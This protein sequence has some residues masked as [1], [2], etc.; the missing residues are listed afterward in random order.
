MAAGDLQVQC[1][2][3][4]C[5]GIDKRFGL[6][7]AVT[8]NKEV[9]LR[10]GSRFRKQEPGRTMSSTMPVGAGDSAHAETVSVLS[11]IA[12][13]VA[14]LQPDRGGGDRLADLRSHRQ[15]L[16]PRH[17]RAGA[18]SPDRAPGVRRRPRRRSLRAQARRA[19]LPDRRGADGT[20]PGV[21]HLCGL[22]DRGTYLHRHLRARHRRCVREPGDGGAAAADH[23]TGFAAARDRDLE[24]GRPGRDHHRPGAR[25]LRFTLLRR[26]CLTASWCCSGCWVRS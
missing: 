3:R 12:E 15:R 4:P 23:S 20:V 5:A 9:E 16:R 19:A 10:D 6:G 25:R 17:G 21:E 11:L 18:I 7:H 8:N 24:R 13:L 1:R 14:I 26:A 22:A 2:S